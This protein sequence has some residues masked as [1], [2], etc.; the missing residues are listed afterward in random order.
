MVEYIDLGCTGRDVPIGAIEAI[1]KLGEYT[2][3]C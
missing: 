2:T 1:Q 3:S